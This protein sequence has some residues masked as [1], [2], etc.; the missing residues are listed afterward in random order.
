VPTYLD[1][2]LRHHRR[3]AEADPRGLDELVEEAAGAPAPRGFA[4]ALSRGPGLAVVAEVK[5]RSPSRGELAPGLDPAALARSYQAGGAAALSVLTDGPH[6]GGSAAD[7]AAAREASTLPVLR[8]DFL[9]DA[10]QVCDARLMGADAVLLIAA[11]LDDAELA[12]L[13]EVAGWL[14]LDAVVEVHDPPELE[15]ALERGAAV[16][17]VNQRN[18]WSFQVDRGL[19]ARMAPL[20]PAGVVSLAES[21]VSR[22]EEVA[23]LAEAGY[24]AVLV[25]EALVTS[26]SPS[27][28]VAQLVRAGARPAHEAAGAG[29]P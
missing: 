2:I 11:A 1:G 17:G 22:P 28:L 15:R 21:G 25:G 19:A 10:R 20:V 18:L 5:R 27:S 23:A 9:V 26:P 7:L 14:G 4:A 8:K 16:V 12:R 3:Q 6:F 29:G 24:D 13:L